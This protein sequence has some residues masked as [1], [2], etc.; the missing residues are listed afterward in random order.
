[1]EIALHHFAIDLAFR[2]RA[3]AVGARVIGDEVAA[4]EVEDG[5][6]QALALDLDGASFGDVCVAQSCSIEPF[7]GWISQYGMESAAFSLGGEA[8]G[9]DRILARLLK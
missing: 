7:P 9:V 5:E 6:D 4:A 1:M 3:G 8:R 2:E